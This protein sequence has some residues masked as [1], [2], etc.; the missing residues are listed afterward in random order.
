MNEPV[1]VLEPESHTYTLDGVRLPGVSEVL[2]AL[3]LVDAQ[4]F[5]EWHRVR[6]TA[7]HLAL[8]FYLEGDLNWG[9]LDPRIV[10]Y[11]ESAIR[12][13]E[14]A[15]VEPQ[16][17]E[18]PLGNR[19]YRFCGTPDVVGT[20]FGDP[21]IIDWKSGGLADTAGLSLAGYD[22]LAGFTYRRRIAVQLAEDGSLP[23]KRDLDRPQDY[24]RF[25]AAADLVNTYLYKGERRAAAA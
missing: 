14:L 21:A 6:G 24:P 11:V 4:W 15:K 23:K 13:L 10:G 12:F 8:R 1:V 17:V 16:M 18:R 20:A 22:I 9:S 7:I 3:G 5:K 19:L 2:G 25:L